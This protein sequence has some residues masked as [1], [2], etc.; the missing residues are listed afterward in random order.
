M[1]LDQIIASIGHLD[2]VG[3]G[4]DG[5]PEL[6]EDPL[7]AWHHQIDVAMRAREARL[8]Q[9]DPQ[10]RQEEDGVT[11]PGFEHGEERG[12]FVCAAIVRLC[13]LVKETHFYRKERCGFVMQ[14]L[15]AA[16]A[17]QPLIYPEAHLVDALSALATLPH[18]CGQ[19]FPWARF[20]TSLEMHMSRSPSTTPGLFAALAR[21][22]SCSAFGPSATSLPEERGAHLLR[23][24]KMIAGCHEL[25]VELGAAW[26]D[27]LH[28]DL[29]ALDDMQRAR[30]DTLLEHVQLVSHKPST[31]WRKKLRELI[32][33]VGEDSVRAML[34]GWMPL[35]GRRA[36]MDFDHCSR[37]DPLSSVPSE[38]NEEILRGLAF[39]CGE[40]G[41]ETLAA[42]LG[43]VA[44]ASYEKVSG[45]GPR[46]IKVGNACIWALGQMDEMACVGQLWRL[47][48]KIAYSSA[49]KQIEAMIEAACERFM[50]LPEDLEELSI[51]TFGLG[52]G[53]QLTQEVGDWRFELSLTLDREVKERWIRQSVNG[54]TQLFATLRE[55][56][57]AT[58]I[59][60]QVV[61]AEPALSA[62]IVALKRELEKTLQA[63]IERLE[64]LYWS[65][66]CWDAGTWFERYLDHPLLRAACEGAIWQ[67]DVGGESIALIVKGNT[68]VSIE[69]VSCP[70][71]RLSG[72]VV[73]LWHPVSAN[74]Q[75]LSAWKRFLREHRIFQPF[76]QVYR[77]TFDIASEQEPGATSLE[78]P[79]LV[80]KQH[81]FVALCKHQGWQAKLQGS[82]QLPAPPER[83]LS[84]MD[85][86]DGAPRCA[87][88]QL[89]VEPVKAPSLMT[90]A[91]AYIYVR[92]ERVVFLNA[93]DE[94][95]EL[96]QVEPV[97]YSELCR[98]LEF[99]SGVAGVKPQQVDEVLRE[100]LVAQTP[101]G[102][103]Y[104]TPAQSAVERVR[105]EVLQTILEEL[106]FEPERPVSSAPMSAS[107]SPNK[108]EVKIAS[109]K[110]LLFD[111]R[112]G[113]VYEIFDARLASD[114]HGWG[115][116]EAVSFTPSGI[117]E[118]CV[119]PFDGDATLTQIVQRLKSIL[120]L[121]QREGALMDAM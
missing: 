117:E 2:P 52:R 9:E 61:R 24:E 44:I 101:D 102:T 120:L 76:K 62:R 83:P 5:F 72:A 47:G 53:G 79:G 95:V 107:S 54:Q 94:L 48:Q 90:R 92:Q 49:E 96:S 65:G 21:Q 110:A 8:E 67:F 63:Q 91:G 100:A 31:R 108:L 18:F 56:E 88:V 77:E 34:L 84:W 86:P 45:H 106:G 13:W 14:I 112:E 11:L 55:E 97:H 15:D 73:R 17:R 99:L 28:Q 82:W 68:L 3:V 66:R 20:L 38:R 71:A 33:Q 116:P 93:C 12:A 50:I 37:H 87:R 85:S 42:V 64:S 114:A 32:T 35:F 119:V 10:E 4:C 46:S 43:D 121:A 105:I 78:L 69:G 7:A 39:L 80:F 40:V 60:R 113:E 41:G 22:K 6:A 81:Q 109:T 19:T 16:L 98:V 26:S 59:P 70:R 25:H 111:V 30:W 51:P 27:A 29:E 74:A 1:K 36:T 118:A 104:V 115:L 75:T 103:G 23:L 89:W 58:I 57:V